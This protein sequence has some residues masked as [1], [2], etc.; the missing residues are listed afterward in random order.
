MQ[1]LQYPRK[2]DSPK[3]ML[4][5]RHSS[6]Y[7]RSEFEA[8]WAFHVK[9]CG[10]FAHTISATTSAGPRGGTQILSLNPDEVLSYR[11]ARGAWL[12]SRSRVRACLALTCAYTADKND[13]DNV[14]KTENAATSSRTAREDSSQTKVLLVALPTVR[15][16]IA[17]T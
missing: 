14:M 8:G 9:G 7:H 13:N 10:D 12:T 1:S 16:S 11:S 4:A 5:R 15:G 3:L 17:V 6:A 2:T